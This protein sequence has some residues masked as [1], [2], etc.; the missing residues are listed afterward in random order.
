MRFRYLDSR[1]VALALESFFLRL[2]LSLSI[3]ASA[4]RA[5][6]AVLWTAQGR[7]ILDVAAARKAEVG[8]LFAVFWALFNASAIAGG[9]L[10]FACV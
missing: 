9:I 4:N 1:R 5:G 7:L 6:A 2:S 10:T 8:T 3:A